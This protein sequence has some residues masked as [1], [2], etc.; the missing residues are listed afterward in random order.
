MS[1]GSIHVRPVDAGDNP[2]AGADV[3]HPVYTP[4]EVR[5]EL[6]N[7]A[8]HEQ[9]LIARPS[10]RARYSAPEELIDN[11]C[12]D[13]PMLSTAMLRSVLTEAGHAR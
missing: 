7:I 5:T 11:T 4:D 1:L 10:G 6:E 8:W 12:F 3:S 2:T 9:W 13:L